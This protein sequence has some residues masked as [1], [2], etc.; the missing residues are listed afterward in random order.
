MKLSLVVPCYNEEE[1]FD[2]TNKQLQALL[3]KL[4]ANNKNYRKNGAKLDTVFKERYDKWND[5][6][7]GYSLFTSLTRLWIAAFSNSAKVSYDATFQNGGSIFDCKVTLASGHTVLTNT[8]LHNLLYNPLGIEEEYDQIMGSGKYERLMVR[9]D[10]I[11]VEYVRTRVFTD[12]M[13][14]AVK[15]FMTEVSNFVNAR[16]AYLKSLGILSEQEVSALRSSYNKIWNTLQSE[17]NA[18][19]TQG[20]IEDIARACADTGT[21]LEINMKHAHFTVPEIQAA[22][23]YDVKFIIGSDA[24]VPEAVGAY[25]GSL[26]RAF[27]AGLEPERIV[28]IEKI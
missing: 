3:I 28:N 22:M 15:V 1:V 20:D 24:H 17:Y 8:Y 21:L 26:A 6:S 25:L 11:F 10:K 16:T 9:M 23:K 7:T 2:E 19:F 13:K 12:E 18:F 27:E 4:I 14:K 5:S